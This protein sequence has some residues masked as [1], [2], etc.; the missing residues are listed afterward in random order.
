MCRLAF[1]LET[2]RYCVLFAANRDEHHARPSAPA[3]W[4]SDTPDVFG[5]RDLERGGSWLAVSRGGRFTAVTNVRKGAPA[6]APRSRGRLCASFAQGREGASDF[7]NQTLPVAHEYGGFNLLCRSG[8]S[9]VY[10]TSEREQS[11]ALAPGVYAMSNA[12]LDVPWPK[13]TLAAGAMRAALAAPN[14]DAARDALFAM[15]ADR[16]AADDSQLP[17]T[18]I[19]R[20][21]ERALSPAFLAGPTY[22]TRAST[23]IEWD[24]RGHVRFE[25]RSFGPS[26]VPQGVVREEWTMAR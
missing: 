12:T 6:P 2:G 7:A 4:W 9:T 5:G 15:L 16:R 18:G 20:A 13:V 10:V 17:D 23:V 8:G 22:G 1:A 3:A 24:R 19:P 14:P 21:L 26:G 25:E 11:Q